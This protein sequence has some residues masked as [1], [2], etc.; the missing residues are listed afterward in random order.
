MKVL[1]RYVFNHEGGDVSWRLCKQTMLTRSTIDAE[2]IV[3]DISTMEDKRMREIL[4]Y[5]PIG[6]KVMQWILVNCDNQTITTE[7]S[8]SNDN[9]KLSRHMK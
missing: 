8:S 5:L 2:L 7:L 9:M 1:T 4:M 6:E 3:L